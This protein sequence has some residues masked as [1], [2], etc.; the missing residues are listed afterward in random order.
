MSSGLIRS[1]CYGM[2]PSEFLRQELSLSPIQ[3]IL[4]QRIF[5][6]L[7]LLAVI[8]EATRMPSSRSTGVYIGMLVPSLMI[9]TRM[10][11][12][13]ALAL[14][15]LLLGA[16]FTGIA[17]LILTSDQGWFRLPLAIGIIVLMMFDARLR[18]M[19]SLAP[20]FFGAITL[21]NVNQPVQAIENALWNIPIL[22]GPLIMTMALSA[23]VLW[24]IKP[25][26]VLNQRIMTRMAGLD[27]LLAMLGSLPAGSLPNSAMP[28]F[29]TSPG[30]TADALKHLD[31]GARDDPKMLEDYSGWV[32][33][34]MEL[35]NLDAGLADYQRLW[36][37]AEI[38][39]P[40]TANEITVIASI[41]I[42]F[43]QA[44][45]LL[46][47]EGQ[48]PLEGTT[49]P[50]DALQA[51]E[52]SQI[53][54]RQYL[55]AARL[56][57][58]VLSLYDK[59]P[60]DIA[61]LA[62]PS[63]SST[64]QTNP[65]QRLNA[66]ENLPV[67]LW[68]L[69]VGIACFIVSLIVQSL[70]ANVVDTA[71]LTTIIVADSTLGAD[72][73]KSI[74]RLS[75]ACLGALLGYFWLILGQPLSDT[76]A[77]FLVTLAP[78]LALCAW[79]AA[80]GPR[81]SYAGLQ[82]GLAFSMI[83]FVE[84]EPGT[85][86]G[87]GWYRVLGIFLGISVMGVV[88]YLVWPVRSIVMTRLRLIQTFNFIVSLLRKNPNQTDFSEAGSVQMLRLMDQNLVDAAYF[89]N[90]ARMEPGSSQPE[91]RREVSATSAIIEALH[92]LSKIMESR[93]RLYLECRPMLTGLM[94]DE[95]QTPLKRAYADQYEAMANYLQSGVLSPN[96]SIL[97]DELERVIGRLSALEA[98]NTLTPR[99]RF[100]V[101][102]LIDLEHK[103]ARAVANVRA[104]IE[105][106]LAA[107]AIPVNG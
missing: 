92:Y 53:L 95:M 21:Y 65:W 100:Y 89:L 8:I 15:K 101:E 1:F 31:D 68:S 45:D 5:I 96:L 105:E 13:N 9:T 30:W 11:Y 74:M 91:N 27:H 106:N 59:D 54:K 44:R 86:L 38:P 33:T 19:Q 25:I 18:R 4:A 14:G 66:K 50:V 35:D 90:F 22:I 61:P 75:G 52:V 98:F 58:A 88:D 76:I 78:C 16:T 23:H 37:D 71:I 93:H 83:V 49:P 79:C 67:L 17:V 63:P 80:T 41:R 60:D 51:E 77:G 94:L 24:P 107:R 6:G 40:I 34:V 12:D 7:I 85:Y 99:E 69:K 28:R 32:A 46:T 70:D 2:K 36:L 39:R 55:T 87:A 42:L 62:P 64:P 84:Q 26:Q 82:M 20:I 3:K 43:E 48:K 73:R 72:F 103:H 102:A 81:I 57:R 104:Q 56:K 97:S 29:H 47:S 10:A